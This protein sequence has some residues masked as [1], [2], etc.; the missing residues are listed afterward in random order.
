MDDYYKIFTL[1]EEVDKHLLRGDRHY[2]TYDG[3]LLT[4]LDQIIQAI[5]NDNLQPL[6]FR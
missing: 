6:R 4:T 5:L 1:V 2:R 3:K